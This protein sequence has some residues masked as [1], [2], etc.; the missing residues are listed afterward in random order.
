M[1]HD[2]IV[3]TESKAETAPVKQ[4]RR[5]AHRSKLARGRDCT[6]AEPGLTAHWLRLCIR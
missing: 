1:T 6:N 4:G 2:L 5:Q 3:R